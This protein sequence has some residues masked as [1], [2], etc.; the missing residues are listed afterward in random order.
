[1]SS[2]EA[3]AAGHVA[4]KLE[5]DEVMKCAGRQAEAINVCMM[6]KHQYLAGDGTRR[7]RRPVADGHE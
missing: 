2:A 3:L 5:I 1:M 6:T 7:Q 4:K